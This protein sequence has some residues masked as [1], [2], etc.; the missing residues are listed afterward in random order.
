MND[1]NPY[2]RTMDAQAKAERRDRAADAFVQW[3][4]NVASSLTTLATFVLVWGALIIAFGWLG[5]L[6]GFLPA[7]WFASIIG[8]A[9]PLAWLGVGYLVWWM[10]G[11]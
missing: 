4:A 5:A 1:Q 10:S 9:W 2:I 7:L 11:G 3:L 8:W 6:I